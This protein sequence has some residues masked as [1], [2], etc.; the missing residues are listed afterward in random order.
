MLKFHYAHTV[1]SN[2]IYSGK[3]L[4]FL[5]S[6]TACF[7]EE[8]KINPPKTPFLPQHTGHDDNTA[9]AGKDTDFLQG[10]CRSLSSQIGQNIWNPSHLH[11]VTWWQQAKLWVQDYT[12]PSWCTPFQGPVSLLTT[13]V[14]NACGKPWTPTVCAW[15]V[16]TEKEGG[17]CPGNRR[18]QN[19]KCLQNG[20]LVHGQG[21][22]NALT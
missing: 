19:H 17:K 13:P 7:T 3:N 21:F 20:V 14:Y 15:W 18:Q 1:P 12:Q 4:H 9:G 6:R 2:I 22:R 11:Q 5:Y 8:E 16:M 10:C